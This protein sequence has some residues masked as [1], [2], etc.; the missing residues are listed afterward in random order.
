[1]SDHYVKW[2]GSLD[3]FANHAVF[4][5]R[6]FVAAHT[7]RGRSAATGNA[8][9]ARYLASGR[10]IRVRRGLYASV[11]V[12]RERTRFMPDEYLIAAK[13]QDDAVLAYHTALSFH[14]TAYSV[15]WRFQTMTSRRLRRFTLGNAEFVSIQA[16]REVRTLPD[17]GGGIVRR[18]HAGAEVRVATIERTLVDLMHAPQH[19][20]G[21]EEIWR[22]IGSVEFLDLAAVAE[23]ALLMRTALTAARV[24]YFLEQHRQ[25]WMVEE[26]HL[27][28]LL[29]AKPKQPLHWD[30]RRESGTYVARWN[31]V[32]PEM[33]LRRGW[34]EPGEAV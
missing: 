16:P 21:W 22:S 5:H 13:A 7:T 30:R 29:R 25:Q 19:G 17:F 2:R 27:E 18:P 12:G 23:H 11:P 1:M 26:K 31:L 34:E 33:I 3:F 32:I 20:G 14:G 10:L 24:G 9:L 8:S 6:E 4:A 28:P 15:W